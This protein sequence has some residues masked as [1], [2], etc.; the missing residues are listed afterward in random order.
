LPNSFQLEAKV[1][2]WGE[3]VFAEFEKAGRVQLNRQLRKDLEERVSIYVAELEFVE[4]MGGNPNAPADAQRKWLVPF[5]KSLDKTIQ[6]LDARWMA[7]RVFQR[8]EQL[9]LE[10]ALRSYNDEMARLK[11]L[12]DSGAQMRE[13]LK[14]PGPKHDFRLHELLESLEFIFGAAG[15]IT[16]ALS[17]AN[18]DELRKSPF[19]DFAWKVLLLKVPAS[20]RPENDQALA[21]FW[22]RIRQERYQQKQ[23]KKQ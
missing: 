16:T 9:T 1:E 4:L 3:N 23:Q 7:V 11:S 8:A 19:I 5:I 18:E 15:G 2:P 14:K 13:E 10:D 20:M 17:R 6:V 22:E 12:L 21:T